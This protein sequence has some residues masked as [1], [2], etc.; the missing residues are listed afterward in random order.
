VTFTLVVNV[1]AAD[2]T[3][4]SREIVAPFPSVSV[5]VLVKVP[6]VN[7]SVPFT[8]EA[9]LRVTPLALLMDNPLNVLEPEPAIDWA[10]APLNVTVPVP[11]LK[12]P[13][14]LDTL[15]LGDAV[16]TTEKL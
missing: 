12:E 10:A 7:V 15:K 5:A 14:A 16:P 2:R 11:P 13:D 1:G 4:V 3:P 9:L 6:F 8:L